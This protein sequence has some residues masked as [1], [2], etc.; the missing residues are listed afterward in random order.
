MQRIVQ[1]NCF[2]HDKGTMLKEKGVI[3]F[4][5]TEK[6]ETE[7]LLKSARRVLRHTRQIQ[8]ES[9]MLVVPLGP[10]EPLRLPDNEQ[11]NELV[12]IVW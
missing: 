8:R 3:T 11:A 1:E 6:Y 4:F 9:A 12:F 7:D 10:S 2:L 5:G